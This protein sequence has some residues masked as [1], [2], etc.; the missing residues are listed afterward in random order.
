MLSSRVVNPTS[1]VQ[2]LETKR[3]VCE[4]L[5]MI[6]PA[7]ILQN[8]FTSTIASIHTEIRRVDPCHSPADSDTLL[9]GN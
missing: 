4:N 7:I 5:L 9:G 1:G 8:H 6:L 2:E 3:R